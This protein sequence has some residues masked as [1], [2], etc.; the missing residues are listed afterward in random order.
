MKKLI[1]AAIATGF[2]L[3]CVASVIA[4][5][6]G[7]AQSFAI[8][9]GSG[10]AFN[11]AL[12]TI[13]G[14]IGSPGAITGYPG[15]AVLLPQFSNQGNSTTTT[16]AVTD[17]LS[18][19]LSNPMLP[20]GATPIG[21]DDL[22]LGSS[23]G[24]AGHYTPG[25][26]TNPGGVALIS[27]SITL[28]TPGV[29]VF[30]LANQLTAAGNVILGAGVD[31]CTV[32]WRTGPGAAN[33]NINS[34]LFSGTV[35]SDGTI[36]LGPGATIVG[37]ALTT[38]T[39]PVTLAGNNTVGGCSGSLAVPGTMSITKA[40]VPNLIATGGTSELTINLINNNSAVAVLTSSFVDI[41]PTGVVIAATP[42]AATN[43]G[44]GSVIAVAG[45]SS[46]SLSAGSTIPGGAPG[47]CSF[48]V[49]VTGATA[50]VYTNT[51]TA[52]S[53]QT[54]SGNNAV[55]AIAILSIGAAVPTMTESALL[56]LVTL[57]AA[58]GVMALQRRRQI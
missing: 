39:G 1:T 25:R 2:A 18:L 50:G 16:N 7:R 47:S 35:V 17:V 54:T 24:L 36:A 46:V 41:L 20:L 45:S 44:A 51:L 29:Y 6:P 56:A 38:A 15:N 43:C 30:T 32:F 10:I 42:T 31:P 9:G 40:F 12:S 27:T 23:T 57:L 19:Y 55:P 58:G 52:N 49:S 4:Q 14:N 34:L 28:D 3:L 8:V 5:N 11:G 26:Y 53:L 22:S 37:R 33:T 13:A 48:H 21:F